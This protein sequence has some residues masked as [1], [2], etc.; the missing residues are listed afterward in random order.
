MTEH[1]IS[2][3][4]NGAKQGSWL[5]REHVGKLDAP[6]DAFD[7]WRLQAAQ[8]EAR[9]GLPRPD[10]PK[11]SVWPSLERKSLTHSQAASG[12]LLSRLTAR[13]LPWMYEQTR[14]RMSASV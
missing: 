7:E 9:A 2:M 14:A 11:S 3:T 10:L 5:L 8:P 13:P 4:V 12:A 1:S 6:I